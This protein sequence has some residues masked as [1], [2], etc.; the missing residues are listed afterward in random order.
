MDKKK[1]FVF[2]V[3]PALAIFLMVSSALATQY[4]VGCRP[5]NLLGYITQSAAFSLED[6]NWYDTEKGL[7]SA[8]FN[9]FIEG[10]YAPT[11]E[12]KFYLSGMFTSDWNYEFKH[13]DHTWN[14]KMF[15]QSRR[16]LYIDDEYWQLL[17]EAH[18]TWSPSNLLIRLGKQIV[19]WGETD[20]F[21]LMD[22]INPLDTRRGF[23]DVQFETTVIPI[24]L[25]RAEYFIPVQTSWLT[26]LQVQT[27]FN[28]N[29]DFIPDQ[30][31]VPGND[32]SGIWSPNIVFP[33]GPGAIARVGSAA[34][35]DLHRPTQWN[36]EGFE[37]GIRLRGIVKDTVISLNYF[38]GR[39][40]DPVER[41]IGPSAISLAYDGSLVFHPRKDGYYPLFRFVGATLARDLNFLAIPFLG[42]AAP[43]LRME[44]IYCFSNTFGDQIDTFERHSEV[45]YAMGLDWKVRIKPLNQNTFFTISP[46]FYFR[47]IL[48]FPD[49]YLLLDSNSQAPIASDTYVSTLMINT[50]YFNNK[51]EPMVFWMR[52]WWTHSDFFKYQLTY[53]P[54]AHWSYAAGALILGGNH[55]DQG[56]DVFDNKDQIYFKISYKWG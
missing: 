38:Y 15:D 22:Q 51:L 8:L 47:K 37:Y 21:R 17:K 35:L 50:S 49:H 39:D 13:N 14:Q 28:P 12:L 48:N 44:A 42:N 3:I 11:D 5:L 23:A 52:D 7:Q 43:V 41:N 1:L 56:F 29:A 25:L 36:S 20:G 18:V 9:F 6:E 31:P 45:R 24:W 4:M 27:I 46:Q 19:V 10:D 54:N 34:L 2:L 33:L 26:D 55:T 53:S 32:I 40:N 16:Y 30:T